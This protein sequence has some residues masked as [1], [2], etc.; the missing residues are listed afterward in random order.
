MGECSIREK[1][2]LYRQMLSYLIWKVSAF[3]L[4]SLNLFP[5]TECRKLNDLQ[6]VM[7]FLNFFRIQRCLRLESGDSCGVWCLQEFYCRTKRRRSCAN[8]DLVLYW[9]CIVMAL[10]EVPQQQRY[11]RRKREWSHSSWSCSGSIFFRQRKF[12]SGLPKFSDG[13]YCSVASDVLWCAVVYE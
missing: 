7:V 4:L 10:Y 11:W 13:K 3:I 8:L 12:H 2:L 9:V 5:T 1:E 6:V